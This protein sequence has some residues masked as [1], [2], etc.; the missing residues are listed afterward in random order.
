MSGKLRPPDEA[1]QLEIHQRLYVRRDVDA[2]Y[3]LYLA[4]RYGLAVCD[5]RKRLKG[6]AAK[7]ARAVELEHGADIPAA[8]RHRLEPVRAAGADEPEAAPRDFKRLPETL[9]GLV[10]FARSA[11]LVDVH[12]LGVLA[13]L[14]LHGAHRVAQLARGKRV[15]AREEK[16]ADDLLETARKRNLDLFTHSRRAF[17]AV[18]RRAPPSTGGS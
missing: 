5:Y 9:Y 10:D 13:F 16:R 4:L 12:H 15:L 17:Q 7:A 3:V 6:R 18:C 1:D 2:A 11:R 14:R 8:A